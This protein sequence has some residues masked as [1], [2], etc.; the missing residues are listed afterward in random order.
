[1]PLVTLM[2]LWFLGS[3]GSTTEQKEFT[4]II[5]M[6]DSQDKWFK[7]KIVPQFKEKHSVKLKVI[8]FTEIWD[9]EK[10]LKMEEESG[11]FTISLVKIPLEAT[12]KLTAL[13]KDFL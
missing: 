11:K 13:G 8:S 10:M 7:E 3:F 9:I 5:R 4:L 2:S 6:M 1:M 12:R